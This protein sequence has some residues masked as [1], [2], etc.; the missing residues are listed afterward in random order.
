MTVLRYTLSYRLLLKNISNRNKKYH[1]KR[2]VIWYA[3]YNFIFN[4]SMAIDLL[5]RSPSLFIFHSLNMF[6]LKQSFNS[7]KTS[8]KL[9]QAH[10]PL[11][12]SLYASLSLHH[13][14]IIQGSHYAGWTRQRIVHSDLTQNHAASLHLLLYV[15]Q[16]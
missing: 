13:G 3:K 12:L 15:P 14:Q 16:M 10:R 11:I 6:Q 1:T 9:P 4:F 5:R 8:H 7:P 2:Y